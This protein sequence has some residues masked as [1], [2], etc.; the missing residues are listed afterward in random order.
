MF[1]ISHC[2]CST[3]CM[4]MNLGSLKFSKIHGFHCYRFASSGKYRRIMFPA[5]KPPT[6]TP[7][8][9]DLDCPSPP[10]DRS[11][12]ADN[13]YNTLGPKVLPISLEFTLNEYNGYITTP[14]KKRGILFKANS[15]GMTRNVTVKAQL[16][17]TSRIKS[18]RYGDIG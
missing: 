12:T 2:D 6:S 3:V 13:A 9:L 11:A 15:S 4:H 16:T 17:A 5:T 18:Y 8:N 7:R 14:V 1:L 10:W